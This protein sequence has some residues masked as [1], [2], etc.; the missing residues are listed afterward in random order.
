[1]TSPALSSPTAPPTHGGSAPRP[2]R[3]LSLVSDLEI[4]TSPIEIRDD[5]SLAAAE[6]IDHRTRL[7]V[8]PFALARRGHHLAL[9][10]GLDELLPISERVTHL[11][12]GRLAQVRL[13]DLRVSRD[14]AIAVV[15]G[16]HLRILDNRS[17]AGTFVNG[18]AVN[19]ITLADG[20]LIQLGPVE[21]RYVWIEPGRRRR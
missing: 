18:H 14:H 8:V 9:D 15:H 16:D 20:D 12:R 6:A 21:F 3:G 4:A 13:E 2:F 11:G 19:A 5:T 7:R 10:R 1:M 17:S